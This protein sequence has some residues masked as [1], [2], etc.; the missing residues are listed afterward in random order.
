ML[1]CFSKF[2]CF[3]VYSEACI[4]LIRLHED[5]YILQARIFQFFVL[6]LEGG[7]RKKLYF[8]KQHH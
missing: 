5:L 6:E 3:Q 2:Q 4:C 7:G 1:Y 8:S